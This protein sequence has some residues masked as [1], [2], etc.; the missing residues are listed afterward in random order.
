[1]SFVQII[2]VLSLPGL[3]KRRASAPLTLL[4][5]QKNKHCSNAVSR[6]SRDKPRNR[7]ETQK[8]FTFNIVI[9]ATYY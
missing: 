6:V 5:V 2:A 4:S 1:M 8:L 7:H 9:S 3:V